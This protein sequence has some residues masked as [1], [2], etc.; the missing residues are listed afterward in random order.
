MTINSNGSIINL[1]EKLLQMD[2]KKSQ[3]EAEGVQSKKSADSP[4]SAEKQQIS[5]II[6]IR[7]E[8]RLAVQ[9]S[10]SITSRDQA[11]EMLDELKRRFED[12]SQNALNAHK[13]ADPNTVMKFYPFE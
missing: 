10:N 13:K 9:S 5:D 7:N 11:Y 1:R 2:K 3:S 8:N 6:G 12:D 4:V